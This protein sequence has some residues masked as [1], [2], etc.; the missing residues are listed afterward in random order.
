MVPGG[1]DRHGDRVL[2]E[3]IAAL[4]LLKP[5]KGSKQKLRERECL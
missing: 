1:H 2:D 3:F 5:Q 4:G